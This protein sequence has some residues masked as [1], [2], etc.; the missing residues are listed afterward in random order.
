MLQIWHFLVQVGDFLSQPFIC[1][2]QLLTLSICN[3]KLLAPL[4]NSDLE[5]AVKVAESLDFLFEGLVV[6]S[7]F[8]LND[9]DGLCESLDFQF[10]LVVLI[11]KRHHSFFKFLNQGSVLCAI[12]CCATCKTWT[13]RIVEELIF[14]SNFALQKNNLGFESLILFL[15]MKGSYRLGLVVTRLGHRIRNVATRHLTRQNGRRE[16]WWHLRSTHL[17]GHHARCKLRWCWPH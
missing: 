17:W 14:N 4:L 10:W 1:R 13:Q 11:L 9:F 5:A 2:L 7:D 3:F 15:K 8:H 12:G 6:F 16:K